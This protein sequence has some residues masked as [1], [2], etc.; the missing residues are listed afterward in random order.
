MSRSIKPAVAFMALA[1]IAPACGDDGTGTKPLP[2]ATAPPTSVAPPTRGPAN[3]TFPTRL[4]GTPT[5]APPSEPITG[6][7]V[8]AEIPHAAQTDINDREL[9]ALIAG[10]T[11]FGLALLRLVAAGGENA[12]LSPFSVAGALTMAY[13]GARG[14][15]ALQ[16]REALALGLPDARVHQAR[17]ELELRISDVPAP[18]P[19]DD[20]E[21][22]QISTANA[23]WGQRGF[24]FDPEFLTILSS[25]YDAGVRLV[26]F[27]ADTGG[28]RMAIN[29]W[30]AEETENRIL[31]LLPEGVLT[32]DTRVV[33]TN[34]IWFKANWLSR[35]A[36]DRTAPGSFSLLD[37]TT[38]TVPLMHGG[39]RMSYFA[40]EGFQAGRLSY[41][42][43]A[44]M[45][46]IAPEIGRYHELLNLLDAE[47]LSVVTEGL[48]T[49]QVDL[50]MPI[51]EFETDL[52]I[53]AT[54]EQ[55]GMVD[56]FSHPPAD[57][58]GIS[59]ARDDL[60]VQDLRHKAFI[61]VDEEG[62]E[63]AAATA[64]AGLRARSIDLAHE[65]ALGSRLGGNR[66]CNQKRGCQA[67]DENTASNR[68]H[69]DLT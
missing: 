48:S 55:L 29:D 65:R 13:A 31:D 14:T 7:L 32:E 21:P 41:A 26:D 9:A 19:D 40:G 60:Y 44:S 53:K 47:L 42:G 62:T 35:L 23:L 50:T 33:L 38:A 16:M 46:V 24:E 27:V 11:R 2:A 58:S 61:S 8:R 20:R 15:T 69:S 37:G 45:I 34:A 57:F 1:L 51:F 66:H 22:L 3:T 12:V 49:H 67:A 63:A 28:A 64:L 17:N 4:P 52:S 56:A 39:G 6:E 30:V 25:A 36:P 43:G 10:N 18:R 68:R 5:T 54:M 59:T